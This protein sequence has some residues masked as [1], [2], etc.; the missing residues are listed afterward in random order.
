M[1][2]TVTI[3]NITINI[4]KTVINAEN[5][6]KE[7]QNAIMDICTATTIEKSNLAFHKLVL[8]KEQGVLFTTTLMFDEAF[9]TV[10][11]LP[12]YDGLELF[13]GVTSAFSYLKTNWE[14]YNNY[15][16][17]QNYVKKLLINIILSTDCKSLLNI[18][19]NVY[20]HIVNSWKNEDGSVLQKADKIR[21]VT[22]SMNYISKFIYSNQLLG[23]NN[24]VVQQR[25]ECS[26]KLAK[27]PTFIIS[28]PDSNNEKWITLFNE[29]L[30]GLKIKSTKK[31]QYAFVRL[32]DWMKEYSED[33]AKDPIVFLSEY[34][35][36]PS[37]K[38]FIKD[39]FPSTL[40]YLVSHVYKF[41]EWIVDTYMSDND[42]DG[43]VTF[44]VPVFSKYDLQILKIVDFKPKPFESTSNPLPTAWRLKIYKILTENDFAW[45]KSISTQYFDWLNPDT[46]LQESVWVPTLAY[47]FVT[48]LEIP[49][50]RIQVLCLDSGE[51]DKQVYDPDTGIWVD[52]QI[53][54]AGYWQKDS[55]AKVKNRG[56]IRNL[57]KPGKPLVGF[58]INTNKTADKNG[59][60]GETEGYDM[61]WQNE[62]VIKIFTDLRQWQQ[63]YNPI[64]VPTKHS[65]IPPS[66]FGYTGTETVDKL[67]VDKF[68]LFR[69]PHKRIA[70][71][72]RNS[73]HPPGYNQ[74]RTFWR[75][76]LAELERRLLIEDGEVVKIVEEW[77]N[78]RPLKVNFNIHGLR[79]ASLIAFAEAGVPIEVLSK[80]VAGHS[81]ILMTIYYLKFNEASI[82]QLLCDKAVEIRSNAA[83]QLKRHLE[84][85]SWENAKRIAVYNDEEC[86]R[87]NT[88][89]GLSPSWSN[90]GYGVCPHGGTRC[91][92][93]GPLFL[94]KDGT[95]KVNEHVPGGKHH[96]LR[97]RHFISGTPFLI[98]MW[99][100]TNK[101]L[102]ESQK[103]ATEYDGFLAELKK[104][105]DQRYTLIKEGRKNEVSSKIVN[106]IK[107]L[108]GVCD[109]RS[110]QLDETLMELHA[111]WRFTESIKALCTIDDQPDINKFSLLCQNGPDDIEF[112]Y[113]DGTRFESISYILQ[114]SRIF[115]FLEDENLEL[116]RERFLDV[117]LLRENL[118]P[119]CMQPL[120]NDEKRMAADAASLFLLTKV[121]ADETQRIYEGKVTLKELGFHGELT[122]AMK[123]FAPL[124]AKS[125]SVLL[126]GEGIHV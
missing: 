13:P 122:M 51:G 111:A 56:V 57:S 34:R 2:N 15:K 33:V 54:A 63:K 41:S 70:S 22:T 21:G 93:G 78:G 4:G 119:L 81:N 101:L 42:N 107:E 5:I 30:H 105:D 58:Y 109:R 77:K 112:G 29:W 64:K 72:N 32:L 102:I 7:V 59:S 74:C 45:P 35:D 87:A 28:N 76:I 37:F 50:R 67:T 20:L 18:T 89:N 39:E 69:T 60:F 1:N 65:T 84:N 91:E 16:L 108:E 36:A 99:M 92:D 40:P 116:E 95:R 114:A 96:C 53:P 3:D 31:H 9:S 55:S 83:D 118:M 52:N 120:T 75:E 97:C 115:P 25:V 113:R 17:T 71:I 47:L 86:F 62:T 125:D 126:S 103:L 85:Q 94:K 24:S 124:L 100:K 104:L 66:V 110:N 11:R 44:G 38:D 106:R 23:E 48:M 80:L 6:D 73:A 14:S 79:V 98:Q 123:E 82:S 121:T 8:L 49:L 68:F 12:S 26:P 10:S 46:Q 90:E 19:P 117:I 61:P 43:A 27:G 88:H